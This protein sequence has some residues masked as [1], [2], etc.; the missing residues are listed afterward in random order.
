MEFMGPPMM[1]DPYASPS[2][3][4]ELKARYAS[5]R[6]RAP[7]KPSSADA[8]PGQRRADALKRFGVGAAARAGGAVDK[9]PSMEEMAMAN[10]R[11]VA[12]D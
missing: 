12:M 3:T 9:I 5:L 2:K 10:V 6:H 8:P 7:A 4:A 11:Q 1:D